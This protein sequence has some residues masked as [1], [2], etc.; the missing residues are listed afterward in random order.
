M[1]AAHGVRGMLEAL[2]LCAK[3]CLAPACWHHKP[4]VCCCM[5]IYDRLQQMTQAVPVAGNQD[6]SY[7]TMFSSGGLQ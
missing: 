6:G 5:Q 4:S 3:P 7:L 1:A 2:K